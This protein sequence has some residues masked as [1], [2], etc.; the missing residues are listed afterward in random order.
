MR[1][2]C[3]L[4]PAWL[5]TVGAVLGIALLD[6]LVQTKRP[7]GASY[8]IDYKVWDLKLVAS[9]LL[10]LPVA[11]AFNVF[12]LSALANLMRTAAARVTAPMQLVMWFAG[13]TLP[14][15]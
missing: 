9:A 15:P 8:K 11:R 6:Y 13:S 7:S 5:I 4:L 3:R 12:P 2:L 10:V 1:A 14:A